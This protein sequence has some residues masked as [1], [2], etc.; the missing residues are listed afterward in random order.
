MPV[1]Y[2]HLKEHQDSYARIDQGRNNRDKP[3]T[4]EKRKNLGQF[5]FVEA[6]VQ[7]GNAETYNDTAEYAHLQRSNTADRSGSAA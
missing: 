6:V 5:N 1:S 2:T 3:C 7:S 4:A